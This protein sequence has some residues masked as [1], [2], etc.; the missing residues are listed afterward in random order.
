VF[1]LSSCRV[2]FTGYGFAIGGAG[3]AYSETA[4]DLIDEASKL[5]NAAD[6]IMDNLP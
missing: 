5:D 2:I 4:Q 1:C 6:Y 3:W